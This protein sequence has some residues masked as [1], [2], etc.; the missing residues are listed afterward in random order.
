MVVSGRTERRSLPGR[1][2]EALPGRHA[3]TMPGR[4]AE[5]IGSWVTGHQGRSRRPRCLSPQCWDA[6]T[7]DQSVRA[8]VSERWCESSVT[9]RLGVG[10][11]TSWPVDAPGRHSR[12]GGQVPT[13]AED[14]SRPGSECSSIPT[15]ASCSDRQLSAPPEFNELT[16]TETEIRRGDVGLNEHEF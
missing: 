15:S 12:G 10:G 16:L 3:E 7:L 13:N 2:V 14:G 9:L 6:R 5:V 8:S 11:S 1:H 4:L